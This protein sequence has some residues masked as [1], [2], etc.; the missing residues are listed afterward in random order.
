MTFKPKYSEEYREKRDR[1]RVM[2]NLNAEERA[3]L[4]EYKI[5]IMQSQDSLALKQLAFLGCYSVGNPQ[6]FIRY[7]KVVLVGNLRRNKKLGVDVKTEMERK[8][9]LKNLDKGNQS[10]PIGKPSE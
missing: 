1:D 7:L 9:K 5:E 2:I 10:L 3:L 6:K 4:N 8:W